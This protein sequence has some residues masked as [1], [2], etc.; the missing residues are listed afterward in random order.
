VYLLLLNQCLAVFI[1]FTEVQAD[2]SYSSVAPEEPGSKSPP[3]AT[4]AVCVPAP[5]KPLSCCI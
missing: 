3:K 5:A 2:P 1:E 4:A